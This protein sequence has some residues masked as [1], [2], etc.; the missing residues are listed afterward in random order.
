[1]K[2]FNLERLAVTM[3]AV[4]IT[5]A[6]CNRQRATESAAD[7]ADATQPV[8]M[9][10]AS[11]E[12]AVRARLYSAGATRESDIDVSAA[13][14]VVTLSGQVENQIIED[15]AM[16]V[17][18]ETEGVTRVE[19][20]L[21]VATSGTGAASNPLAKDDSGTRD[22]TTLENTP[23]WITTKIQAQYFVNP[24][25]KGW[26]I[27]VTTTSGGVVE[28]RGEVDTPDD[29]AEAVR[30]A[31]ATEGV[32]RIEDYLRVRADTAERSAEPAELANSDPWI[33]AKVQAKY[34]VDPDV[35]ALNL[36]VTTRDGVVTLQ[37]T[38]AT[39]AERRHA[40]AIARNTDGVRDVRDE[41]QV[42]TAQDQTRGTSGPGV[43]AGVSDPWIT[44]KIQSKFFLDSDVK[45]HRIDVDTRNGVVTLSGTVAS[46]ERRLMAEQIARDTDGVARVLNRL[47]VAP[48]NEGYVPARRETAW[49][50]AD[51]SS[52]DAV[53]DI[54]LV[55]EP[56]AV[57]RRGRIRLD[58]WHTAGGRDNTM[59]QTE[60]CV[61]ADGAAWASPLLCQKSPPPWRPPQS[62]VCALRGLSVPLRRLRRRAVDTQL[63]HLGVQGRGLQ[64]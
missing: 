35:K 13:D 12:T 42:G 30:I 20:R 46:A 52:R 7:N 64:P 19:D 15:Q 56:G 16:T 14:T 24:E 29:K 61:C 6:G 59:H 54:P 23:G 34:F 55:R 22:I 28:L 49:V 11:L 33:T 25:I 1:M 53:H 26:N 10:D 58:R 43:V 47:M 3:V 51:P 31:R 37:G 63:L 21:V 57:R 2:K 27:D 48:R 45:G 32:T 9:S 18:R 5:V 41:L 4:A 50:R 39:D 38:V 36:D 40:V 17:A 8:E 62:T 44:T 60:R